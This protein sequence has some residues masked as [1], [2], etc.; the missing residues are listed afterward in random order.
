M[1][2][3]AKF[4]AS[5]IARNRA[6]SIPELSR[7]H[8]MYEKATNGCWNWIG[9]KSGN[10]YGVFHVVHSGK[11]KSEKS[12]RAAWRLL[13]GEDA[14]DRFVLHTCD[15]RA[16][17][18]PAHLYLGDHTKN[19][20]DMTDRSRACSGD[21]HDRF[22]RIDGMIDRAKDLFRQGIT[23]KAIAKWLM[24][25]FSTVKAMLAP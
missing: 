18:N 12:N 14:G 8:A 5:L 6:R 15:N 10:G 4:T 1:P 17:V 19:M 13:K 2:K 21:R 3:S 22:I 16:C 20:R 11:Q 7:F 23:R 24:V 9:G 25:D